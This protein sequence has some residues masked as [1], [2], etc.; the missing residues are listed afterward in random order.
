MDSC[1]EIAHNHEANG[2]GCFCVRGSGVV[3]GCASV[4]ELFTDPHEG[5]GSGGERE[6]TFGV[7]NKNC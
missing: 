3:V 2:E 4:G 1:V 5:E 7:C 6:A